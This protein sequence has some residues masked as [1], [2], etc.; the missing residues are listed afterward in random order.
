M[1]TLIHR[2]THKVISLKT[3]ERLVDLFVD[4]LLKEEGGVFHISHQHGSRSLQTLFS[5]SM[6][7]AVEE[8]SALCRVLHI[9]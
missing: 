1:L 3:F 8:L 7:L 9:N 5:E 6:W 2:C 4:T